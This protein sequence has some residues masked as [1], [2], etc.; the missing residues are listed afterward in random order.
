MKASQRY[1]GLAWVNYDTLYCHQAAAR[2][3]RDW[4]QTN[5]SLFNLC[6][7]GQLRDIEQCQHC[8]T[9]AHT[10]GDCAQRDEGEE[11]VSIQLLHSLETVTAA[12]SSKAG[13]FSPQ[14][15]QDFGKKRTEQWCL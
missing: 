3:W 8:G 1:A 9:T 10:S 6:F 12:L 11:R 15:G 13:H 7:T 2:K 14:R 4:S 5:T